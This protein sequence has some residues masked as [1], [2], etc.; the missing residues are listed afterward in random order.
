MNGIFREYLDKFFILFLDDILIY[1]KL[2]E[3]HEQ[4]L[5][6]VYKY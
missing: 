4:H 6:M 3:E 2:K 5:N 1:Y